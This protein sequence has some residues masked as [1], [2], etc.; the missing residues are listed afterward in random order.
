MLFHEIYGVYIQAVSHI[1]QQ[2][3]TSNLNEKKMKEIIDQYAF[4]ESFLTIVP[5]LKQQEYQLLDECYHTPLQNSPSYPV[6]MLEKRWL[7]A[8]L[9][10]P[11][12]R[13]FN[14]DDNL[15]EDLK[16]IEPLFHY[17]D[18]VVFDAYLDGDAIEDEAY[19]TR[20]QLILQ[21]LHEQRQLLIIY[22][23]GNGRIVKLT[24][25]PYRLEYSL[26]DQKFRLITAKCTLNL[27]RII[28]CE[29]LDSKIQHVQKPD[30]GMEELILELRDERNTLERCLLH[31]AHF[32]KQT[33]QLDDTHY[34]IHLH[35]RLEDEAELII[36]ILSFGPFLKV[37]QPQRI[38]T[39]MIQRL[40]RQKSC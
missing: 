26:K 28:D 25:S 16:E 37:L 18:I 14:K 5:A 35:Y 3:L 4:P 17:N 39:D 23:N 31:F 27:S 13:L 40:R 1:L 22:Q 8:L 19:I 10:D 30:L 24:V 20:F 38:K 21:S 9:Q 15:F 12:I 7:K 32:E 2:A 29:I 34:R 6:S 11:R 36:R 33:T